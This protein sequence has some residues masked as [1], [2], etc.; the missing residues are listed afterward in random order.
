MTDCYLPGSRTAA[1]QWSTAEKLTYNDL[2]LMK[3][4]L[5][6]KQRYSIAPEVFK[7][8]GD[9]PAQYSRVT[10]QSRDVGLRGQS[11]SVRGSKML[12]PYDTIAPLRNTIFNGPANVDGTELSCSA[13]LLPENPTCF[14]IAFTRTSDTNELS[15]GKVGMF[16][17]AQRAAE[18]FATLY[19]ERSPLLF[20]IPRQGVSSRAILFDA[21]SI[22]IGS[23]KQALM[24]LYQIPN[25][26]KA[27]RRVYLLSVGF[28]GLS[29]ETS[30]Y[31]KIANNWPHLAISLVIMVH[32]DFAGSEDTF[33][34]ASNGTRHAIMPIQVLR[35]C[36]E[37]T[38]AAPRICEFLEICKVVNEAKANYTDEESNSR[39]DLL[40][41]TNSRAKFRVHPDTEFENGV[42]P[43][44]TEDQLLEE[45]Q[46]CRQDT[47]VSAS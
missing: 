3:T 36:I 14:I 1:S 43:G 2:T 28:D 6:V 12:E 41:Y 11:A 44:L 10:L 40:R 18:S 42:E 39:R 27:D 25:A 8:D 20:A 34:P 33:Q 23:G 16:R 24:E 4:V 19:N 47:K 37:G 7:A 15:Y 5:T 38:L 17:R 13:W 9:F 31:V 22:P 45:L 21:H 26:A 35:L 30:H 32:N 29:T 46:R